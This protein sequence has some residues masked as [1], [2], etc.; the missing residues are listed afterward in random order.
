VVVKR[1]PATTTAA[2]I[3]MLS[4]INRVIRGTS[5]AKN[6]SHQSTEY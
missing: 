2:R 5:R 3:T 6:T 4:N 1:S